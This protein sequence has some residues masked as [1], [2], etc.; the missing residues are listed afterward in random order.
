MFLYRSAIGARDVG[1]NLLH[2]VVDIVLSHSVALGS[3]IR[4]GATED[5]G[6]VVTV[7]AATVALAVPRVFDILKPRKV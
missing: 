6:R 3:Q 2:G 1:A 4:T 7:V 5:V